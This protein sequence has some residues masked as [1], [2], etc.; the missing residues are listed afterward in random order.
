MKIWSNNVRHGKPIPA[1]NA[2]GR[3]ASPATFS[4]NISP[5]LAW[6]D[7]PDGTLSFA[8]VCVDDDVP[9][10]PDDVNQEGRVVPASLPRAPF[11]HWV[12]SDVPAAVREIAEGAS[13]QGVTAKGKPCGAVDHGV[14]G[15]NDY[16]SWFGG[17]PDMGGD[18]GGYD[19]PF[20]PW[21]DERMHHYHFV[22]Y[23]LDIG[24]I[25][26]SGP[27]R[28]ADLLKAIEGHVLAKA[29]ISATYNIYGD[30]F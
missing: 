4:D 21:N 24:S 13:S 25:G 28:G 26:L 1:A 9:T 7:V 30:A 22:L 27:F 20:P 23:A 14:Q 15:A 5:H 3:P 18:Y 2:M 6:N 19:G 10:R 17:D 16:T 8:L 12:L 11:Y 29:A